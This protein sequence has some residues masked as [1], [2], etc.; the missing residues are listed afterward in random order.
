MDQ[1]LRWKRDG[2]TWK[3]IADELAALE[4]PVK[5]DP[6]SLCRFIK[7][8]E[9]KPYAIG[10]DPRLAAI[11]AP[12]SPPIPPEPTPMK[13]KTPREIDKDIKAEEAAKRHKPVELF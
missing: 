5:T 6:G 7:R 13:P 3:Q 8:Y 9:K 2:S 4:P 11:S 12:A 1:I 10:T